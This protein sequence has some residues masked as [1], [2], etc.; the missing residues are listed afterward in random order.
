M[1][2]STL[3]YGQLIALSNKISSR[4]DELF[5]QANALT[6]AG[7]KPPEWEWVI[8]KGKRTIDT[9]K[10][11]DLAKELRKAGLNN[12]EIYNLNLKG[13]TELNKLMR[14]HKVSPQILEPYIIPPKETK[15]LTYKGDI[16]E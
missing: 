10:S 16:H 1:D 11:L 4:M 8:R 9:D 12:G 2:I 3:S 14:S 13:I 5:A 15:V 6:Q 7:N